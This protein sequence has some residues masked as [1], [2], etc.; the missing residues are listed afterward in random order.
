MKWLL[1]VLAAVA[2]VGCGSGGQATAP[3]T[4]PP[5]TTDASSPTAI[6][7]VMAVPRFAPLERGTYSIDPDADP[8]TPLRVLYTI[9]ADGWSMWI[10][11]IKFREG[12]DAA[13]HVAVSVAAVDNLVIDGCHDHAPADPPVGPSVEDL[14]AA[15]ADL[16]PFRVRSPPSDVAAYGYNGK[17]VKLTV[18]PMQSEFRGDRTHFTACNSGYLRSWIAPLLSYTFWGYTGEGHIEEF[19]ILDVK[20][21]RLVIQAN[22]SPDSPAEDLAEM[23]AIL[24]SIRIES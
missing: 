5:S 20:G 8:S 4:S 13:G 17:H 7:D 16:S 6:R 19:W 10:G 2:L 9:P 22:W 24:D 14:A 1:V 23:R 15:L 12:P 3:P 21:D 18:P 11:A